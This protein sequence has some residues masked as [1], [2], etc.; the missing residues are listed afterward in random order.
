MTAMCVCVC[1]T[2]TCLIRC[3]KCWLLLVLKFEM[4]FC[5]TDVSFQFFFVRLFPVKLV[6]LLSEV[7][8]FMSWRGFFFRSQTTN[9]RYVGF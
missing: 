7:C 9:C 6:N 1:E 2:K 4:F 5:I 8:S 3:Q